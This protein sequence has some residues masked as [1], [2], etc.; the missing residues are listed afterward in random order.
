MAAFAAS[1]IA[2]PA[3]ARHLRRA[4]GAQTRAKQPRKP[5]PAPQWP[6]VG[7]TSRQTSP[8]GAEGG[9]PSSQKFGC[10]ARHGG[11][12]WGIPKKGWRD[13]RPPAS[14][15]NGGRMMMASLRR[16]APQRLP[17]HVS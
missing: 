4:F 10:P 9:C 15:W 8:K 16:A 14:A 7:G 17:E 6:F 5:S 13:E 3:A 1:V 2:L 11:A 12:L